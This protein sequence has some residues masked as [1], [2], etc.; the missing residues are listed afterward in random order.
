M[1]VAATLAETTVNTAAGNV[2]SAV[3]NANVIA[4]LTALVSFGT[5]VASADFV[6]SIMQAQDASKTGAK[7]LKTVTIAGGAQANT[8]RIT[9]VRRED[10]DTN[11]NFS[12][13][14]LRFSQTDVTGTVINAHLLGSGGPNLPMSDQNPSSVTL[15]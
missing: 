8:Q 11:N 9:S 15:D 4:Q 14:F 3:V 2:D 6:Y 7:V 12:H 5:T 10:F 1:T 13:G